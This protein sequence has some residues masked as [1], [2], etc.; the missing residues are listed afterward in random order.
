MHKTNT[1]PGPITTEYTFAYQQQSILE[2]HS[3]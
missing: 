3:N 1:C 2:I